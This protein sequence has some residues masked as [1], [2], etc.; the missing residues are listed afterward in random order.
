MIKCNLC[1]S[2]LTNQNEFKS[3]NES[4]THYIKYA[5]DFCQRRKN[6]NERKKTEKMEL[7]NKNIGQKLFDILYPIRQQISRLDIG[8]KIVLQP[9]LAGQAVARECFEEILYDVLMSCG[10]DIGAFKDDSGIE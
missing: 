3:H 2:I 4:Q 5:K 1:Q 6:Y 8:G 7:R 9:G 10:D